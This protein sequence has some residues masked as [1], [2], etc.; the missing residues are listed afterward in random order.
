MIESLKKGDRVITNGGLIVEIV[1]VEEE[2]FKVKLED[3]N[4]ARLSK[5]YIASKYEPTKDKKEA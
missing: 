2:F 5:D 1:K 4:F 3:N